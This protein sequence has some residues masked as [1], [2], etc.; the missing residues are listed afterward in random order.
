VPN[1]GNHQVDLASRSGSICVAH[2]GDFT[3]NHSFLSRKAYYLGEPGK[4]HAVLLKSY[5]TDNDWVAVHPAYPTII[6]GVGLN[7]AYA[8]SLVALDVSERTGRIV[9]GFSLR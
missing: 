4:Y 1:C 9:S 5:R 6:V 7:R 2:K 8:A 3:G